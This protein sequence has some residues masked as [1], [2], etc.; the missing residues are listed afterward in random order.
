MAV[1]KIVLDVLLLDASST[2]FLVI[3]HHED[4]IHHL[5]MG[6][7]VGC[8]RYN[9]IVN[10][11]T[12]SS[13][14]II[15]VVVAVVAN[16][17][18]GLGTISTSMERVTI[19]SF[20]ELLVYYVA[21]LGKVVHHCVDTLA[22]EPFRSILDLVNVTV[23]DV[24]VHCSVKQLRFHIVVAQPVRSLEH[25]IVIFIYVSV[26]DAYSISIGIAIA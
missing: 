7:V 20:S 5:F 12:L 17:I 25:L 9:S 18:L 23:A 19:S 6:M 11:R 2:T 1:R 24:L 22:Y 15:G 26:I 3:I 10:T 4:F 8:L 21:N 13:T 16:S 14:A